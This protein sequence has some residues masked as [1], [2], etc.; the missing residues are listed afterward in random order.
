MLLY[1]NFSPYQPAEQLQ[2]AG[3]S[4]M[5]GDWPRSE[6]KSVIV[7]RKIEAFLRPSILAIGHALIF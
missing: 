4:S 1:I 5:Q 2:L 3:H 7:N 6:T